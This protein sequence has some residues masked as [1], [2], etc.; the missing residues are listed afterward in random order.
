[1]QRLGFI[2]LLLLITTACTDKLDTKKVEQKLAQLKI[3]PKGRLEELPQAPENIELKYTKG[4]ERDPFH[5]GNKTT[6]LTMQTTDETSPLQE[7]E[8]GQLSFRGSMQKGDQTYVLILTPDNQ[9]FRVTKG[10][11]LGRNN[12]EIIHL[13]RH[14]ITLKE[15]LPLGSQLFEQERTLYISN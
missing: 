5:P 2:L 8:L 1:M 13:D 9:L 10:S 15:Y 3:K 14:T 12:G 4:N 6:S 11:K 7:Y